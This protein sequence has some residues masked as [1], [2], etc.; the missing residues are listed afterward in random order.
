MCIRDSIKEVDTDRLAGTIEPSVGEDLDDEIDKIADT[1]QD[2][3]TERQKWEL[4]KI[5]RGLG[6]PQP[7]ELGRALRNSGVKRNLIRWAVREMRCPVCES[8]VKPLARKPSSLPR[9]LKFN[10]VV[11]CDLFEFSD[12]G[13]DKVFL[14]IICWGTGYQMCC[15]CPDKTSENVTKAFASVWTKH[16]GMPELLITDQG[17]E[18]TG[19]EFTT[20]VAQNSCLQHFIDSQS[21]WQQGRTE[22]AGGSLKEDLRKVAL[23]CGIVTEAEL[24]IAL[25]MAV[26][27]RNRYPNRSGYSAH[28]RVFGSSIRLPGSLMSED[29]VDRFLVST[30]PTTEFHRCAVIRDAALKAHLKSSDTA[31]LQRAALGRSRVPPK[32]PVV[33]GDVVYVWRNNVKHDVKGWVGPGLVVCVNSA[34]SSVWVSMR[35]V[36]VKC[37]VERVRPATDEEWMGSEIIRV[38]SSD[39]KVRLERD[40]QRGYVDATKEEGPDP[41][42]EIVDDSPQPRGES[43]DGRLPP[44]PEDGPSEMPVE[45]SVEGDHADGEPRAVGDSAAAVDG[46]RQNS[47]CRYCAVQALH[48]AEGG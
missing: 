3:P 4:L 47:D 10:Q 28:Q 33:E 26:D 11:G 9:T 16:Y 31:A 44:I 7:N 19:R 21:P 2:E 34:Q 37:N 38:L 24:D 41:D 8:R 42:N 45:R 48:W 29:P 23:E 30:D 5:H 14:N 36:L 12:F 39:A 43:A 27:A 20:Y 35:G 40:A 18:F 25:S 46:L 15:A 22:R 1:D 32:R 13:F 17:T 6:H